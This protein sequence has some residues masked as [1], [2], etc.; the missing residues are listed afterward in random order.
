MDTTYPFYCIGGKD[1]RWQD[2]NEGY[3]QW[4]SSDTGDTTPPENAQ[5]FK[6]QYCIDCLA[7]RYAVAGGE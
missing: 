4:A 1:H 3:Y 5:Y 6:K 2:T 7:V